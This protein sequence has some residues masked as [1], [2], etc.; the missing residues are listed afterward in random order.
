MYLPVCLLKLSKMQTN[1]VKT[2]IK[3]RSNISLETGKDF[4]ITLPFELLGVLDVKAQ[5]WACDL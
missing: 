5:L 4:E 2:K 3:S 1:M